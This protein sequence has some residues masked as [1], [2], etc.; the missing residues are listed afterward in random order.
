[1]KVFNLYLC[2]EKES[3]DI[4]HPD[5]LRDDDY[6]HKLYGAFIMEEDKK[7]LR[8]YESFATSKVW[9]WLLEPTEDLLTAKRHIE[10][11]VYC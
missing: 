2:A 8:K 11:R 9:F 6:F 4:V 10:N 7:V 1:M 3:Y 5:K